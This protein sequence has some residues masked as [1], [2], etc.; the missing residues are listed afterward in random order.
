MQSICNVVQP[1]CNPVQ[2]I[3]T[4]VRPICNP[5]Q[6]ISNVAHPHAMLCSPYAML[7]SPYAMLC[8]PYAMRENKAN[9]AQFKLHWAELGIFLPQSEAQTVS[10]CTLYGLQI[11]YLRTNETLQV[12]SEWGKYP[13]VFVLSY[14]HTA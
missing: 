10:H 1:I 7:C 2:P 3:C 5:V 14:F 11:W 13:K 4:V 6:P 12:T 9:S 8:S